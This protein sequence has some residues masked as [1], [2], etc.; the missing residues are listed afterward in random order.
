MDRRPLFVVGSAVALLAS[1]VAIRRM[2]ADPNWRR[3][4]GFSV[5]GKQPHYGDSVDMN[6]EDSFPASD[7]PSF[8]STTAGVGA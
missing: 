2:M 7:P 5:R 3:R 4:L 6:S 8:N 1:A